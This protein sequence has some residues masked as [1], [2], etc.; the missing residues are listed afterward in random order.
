MQFQPAHG[1]GEVGEGFQL[2][3]ADP[4]QAFAAA[5][6]PNSLWGG[7]EVG[8]IRFLGRWTNLPTL[9]HYIQE[10]TSDRIAPIIPDDTPKKL[11]SL[12]RYQHVF[13]QPPRQHWST[14]FNRGL[15]APAQAQWRTSKLRSNTSTMPSRTN[16]RPG[17]ST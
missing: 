17:R 5:R 1:G 6:L 8:R 3:A 13:A 9:E 14:F 12:L 4:Q 2:I 15:Q 10:A 11:A 7:V 16:E